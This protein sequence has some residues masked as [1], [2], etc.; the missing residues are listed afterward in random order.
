[1]VQLNLGPD[2]D[3][4]VAPN[5]RVPFISRE[6]VR[7]RIASTKLEPAAGIDQVRR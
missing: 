2:H 3:D 7:N 5:V 1:M 6:Q 4:V